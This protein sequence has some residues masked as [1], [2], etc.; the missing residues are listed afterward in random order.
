MAESALRN[1]TRRQEV[2]AFE[3][4]LDPFGQQPQRIPIYRN[5][6]EFVDRIKNNKN[7]P[8]INNP[9][10]SISTHRMA[11]EVD[12]NG[13]WYVFPT[14]Q[15]QDGELIEYSDSREAMDAAFK[16]GNIL[17]APNK[18]SAFNYA[19]GAYK[20]DTGIGN[21]PRVD[22]SALRNITPRQ[23]VSAFEPSYNPF[24]PAFRSSVANAVSN[25]IGSSNIPGNEGYDRSRY[26]DLLSGSVDFAPGLGEAA[27]VGDVRRELAAGN[28]GNAAISG[29]ATMLGVV[30]IVGDMAAGAVKSALR[31]LRNAPTVTP[32]EIGFDPRFDDR[33]QEQQRIAGSQFNYSQPDPIEIPELSIYDLEG[34]PF[35]L[36]MADRTAAG[37][38]LTGIDD[39]TFDSPVELRG[40]Q[41]YMFYNPGQVW[42]S[43]KGPVSAM[44]NRAARMPAASALGGVVENSL[45]LP[46]RMAPSGGDYSTM[47][48]DAMLSYARANMTKKTIRA[49]NKDIK[50]I[51]PTFM[52]IENP[53]SMAQLYAAGGD[54]RKNVQQILDKKY[55]DKGGINIGQAR[56]SS[57]DPSQYNA[58]DVGLGNVGVIEQGRPRFD[59]SGHPTYEQGIPGYGLGTLKER[60]ISA[61]DLLPDMVRARGVNINNPDPKDIYTLRLGV[62]SGRITDSA[63]RGIEQRRLMVK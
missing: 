23:E 26:S 25:L 24:N 2:S 3:P 63:L 6:P 54:V 22:L 18:Q 33:V 48:T 7:Y 5:E 35:I 19:G 11:A 1:I 57:T 44:L 13:N 41:D 27:G 30:P 46:F 8:V 36:G 49:A 61:F 52:G 9:D 29:G 38:S 53:E 14:I 39:V 55:R 21:K 59:V 56:L 4:Y 51:F 37:K 32:G 16:T 17:R 42:A 47:V 10:G 58:M 15:M 43:D 12:A 62:Q 31:N 20:K 40:G 34:K 45:F 50:E 28:Y 60:D